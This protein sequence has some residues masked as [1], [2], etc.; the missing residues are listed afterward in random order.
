L[1]LVEQIKEFAGVDVFIQQSESSIVYKI[2]VPSI[3]LTCSL[4][5][6]GI[7]SSQPPNLI[8]VRQSGTEDT[9]NSL[10]IQKNTIK[11][12]INIEAEQPK[13]SHN[14]PE[15]I[16]VVVEDNKAILKN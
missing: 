7:N 15:V 2:V 6:L 4:P 10:H 11:M 8:R 14:K 5:D 16:V 3:H 13:L 9:D 1:K 12:N